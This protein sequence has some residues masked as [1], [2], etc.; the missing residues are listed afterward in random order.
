MTEFGLIEIFAKMGMFAW[1]ILII[2]VIMS[3]WSIGVML[4]RLFAYFRSRRESLA[5]AEE[6]KTLLPAKQLKQAI[7][8]GRHYKH[9]YLSLVLVAGIEEYV[10]GQEALAAH[11]VE[12]S[13][14]LVDAVNRAIERATARVIGDLKKGLGSLATIGSVAPF[15]GL[16]G[17]VVGIVNSFQSMAKAGSGGIETVSAGIAEALIATAVGLLAAIPAVMMYNFF[18]NRVEEYTVDINDAATELVDYFLKS[19]LER[20]AP[21]AVA[22]SAPAAGAAVVTAAK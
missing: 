2:L 22:E 4:E 9:G 18:T 15:V 1:V 16:L 7:E 13:F 8:R 20:A 14:D 3:L 17:T 12:G 6:L 19:G 21:A 11:I 5:Y 10:R